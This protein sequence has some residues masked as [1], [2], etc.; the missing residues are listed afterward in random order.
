M[1]QDDMSI[2]EPIRTARFLTNS[3]EHFSDAAGVSRTIL[4]EQLV[5]PYWSVQVACQTAP[6]DLFMLR[7]ISFNLVQL[8]TLTTLHIVQ[9]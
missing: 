6:C 9:Q 3:Q 8:G 2:H 7:T 1:L 4:C 5:W